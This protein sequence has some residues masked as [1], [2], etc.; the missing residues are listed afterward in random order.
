[1]FSIVV[2]TFNNLEYL[3]L[4]ISSIKKNSKFQ[5]EIILHINEGTDGTIDYAK[6][7]NMKYTYTEKN[8]GL[9][10]AVNLA[11]AKSS[12]EYILYSHDDMYFCPG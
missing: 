11:A 6:S 4:L 7:N 8:V 5:H 10:T 1:M 12:S 3:K 2:P 9:C